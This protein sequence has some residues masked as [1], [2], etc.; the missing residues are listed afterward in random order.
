MRSSNRW[1]KPKSNDSSKSDTSETFAPTSFI[2]QLGI[3]TL[4]E[5]QLKS[6]NLRSDLW[7][8]AMML[9]VSTVQVGRPVI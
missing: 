7:P 3:G 6:G 1:P 4:P 9:Q 2:K 5:S 8:I